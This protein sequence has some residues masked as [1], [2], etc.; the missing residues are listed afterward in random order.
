MVKVVIGRGFGLEEEE[1]KRRRDKS[2][3]RKKM[4]GK[5]AWAD[6]VHLN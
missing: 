1:Q 4:T 6:T 3:A 5:G 2:G